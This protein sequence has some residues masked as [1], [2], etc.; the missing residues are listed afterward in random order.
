MPR[1]S[2]PPHTHT[3][4]IVP[5]TTIAK[6][7]IKTTDESIHLHNVA[8]TRTPGRGQNA[9]RFLLRKVGEEYIHTPWAA[10]L[11]T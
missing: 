8:P 7:N 10:P 1:A 2:P 6:T 11:R 9:V 5:S 4:Q 3:Q